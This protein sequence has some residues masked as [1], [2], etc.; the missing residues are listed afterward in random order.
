MQQLAVFGLEI[1]VAMKGFAVGLREK[2]V[3]LFAPCNADAT[4]VVLLKCLQAPQTVGVDVNKPVHYL[5]RVKP[6]WLMKTKDEWL[7]MQSLRN[8]SGTV[9]TLLNSDNA[10]SN[11]GLTMD[12][13]CVRIFVEG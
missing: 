11:C 10:W 9:A 12:V 5:I 3:Q 2:G 13:V 6:W 7:A 1:V 8:P 4:V